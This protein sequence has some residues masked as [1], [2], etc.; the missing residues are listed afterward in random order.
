MNKVILV[1]SNT[2]LNRGDQ[3]LV[4][5][6]IRLI[7]DIFRQNVELSLIGYGDTPEEWYQQNNQTEKLGYKILKPILKH[8]GRKTKKSDH[9]G[10]KYGITT[11]FTWGFWA[12]VDLFQSIWLLSSWVSLRAFGSLFLGKQ[13]KE[14]YKKYKDSDAIFVK[15][16]GFI[17]SYGSIS[18]IYLMY[19]LLFHINLGLALKKPVF[20]FPNSIGPLKNKIASYI[21]R[22][23]LKKCTLVTAREL[24]S[25]EFLKCNDV[26]SKLYP[27][28][29][30]FLKPADTDFAEY[31]TKKGVN[32]GNKNVVLTARPYRFGGSADAQTYYIKYIESFVTLIEYLINEKKWGVTLFAHTLG[33]STHE[34]DRLAIR[35]I[36]SK[37]P[38]N[39]QDKVVTIEDYDLNCRDVEK[40][41]SYYDYLV[42]TRF[43]SVIFSLNVNIPS[44]AIAYGGN[45]GTGIMKD[46]NLSEYCIKIEEING[47]EL[48]RVFDRIVYN[49]E[50]YI[51]ILNI[52]R[53]RIN[54]KRNKL[55]SNV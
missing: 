33:P 14:T 35:D 12:M 46:F 19:F 44:I 48:T 3:A 52:R 39:I 17:H 51:Q 37:L 15:G 47:V 32:L 42:G 9:D 11:L 49:R 27:D 16:G 18:D 31:L 21:A 6:S 26:E 29:G 2:D 4:W 5:E 36:I 41:Y 1:P 8:P 28:L 30:F 7:S 43:H 20:V 38:E 34:D 24:V 54:Q 50:S 22:K 10:V 13:E 45:K 55:E 23:T 25:N 40:I 53:A